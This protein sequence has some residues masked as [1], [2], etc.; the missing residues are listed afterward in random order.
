M[1]KLL[2]LSAL[3]MASGACMAED[4]G[5]VISSMPVMQQVGVPRQVCSTEQV[6][7]QAPKSGA[8]AVMGAIAGGAMGN[9]VGRGAGNAAA[10]MLGLVG[11]AIVGDR[12]E[13]A[14][15]VQL[16]SVQHCAT[17]TF[18]ENRTVGYNV[19]YEFGGKQYAVQM[20]QD[21]GPTIQLNVSPLGMQSQGQGYPVNVGT[22]QP[23]YQRAPVVVEA[24]TVYQPYFVQPYYPPVSLNLDYGYWGGHR[25]WR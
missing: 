16:Q 1:N 14:S 3:L 8:G 15:P 25:H 6:A 10:T 7:V 22:A 4:V 13:G 12:I 24:S 5:R 9:A 11:G 2:T 23:A 17:Q 21:P 18:V 19:Q 20:P